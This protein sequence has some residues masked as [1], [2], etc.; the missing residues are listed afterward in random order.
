MKK[1]TKKQ[2]VNKLV[3]LE[4]DI[5]IAKLRFAIIEA[6]LKLLKLKLGL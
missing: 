1:E 5:L 4:A 3:K 2:K 6:E